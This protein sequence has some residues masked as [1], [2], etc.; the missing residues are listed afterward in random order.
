MANPS[1]KEAENRVK[2]LR[3]VINHHRTLYHVHDK[4]EISDEALDSLKN[5]L[6]TLEDL[7]PELIT[8]DSPTQRVGGSALDKFSKIEH[9]VAQWSFD[10]AFSEDDIRA[11]DERVKRQLKKALDK[12]VTPTYTV[13]LKID[14]FKVILSYKQGVLVTAAT[15]GDGK[16]GEDVTSNIKTIDSIP[17]RLEEEIDVVAEGEIW[18]GDHE[19]DRI[20]KE[21]AKEGLDLYA[22]PR[23]VAAGTVRQLDPKVVATRKLDSFI[24]DLAT[25]SASIPDTQ[26]S[27]LQRLQELGFKTNPHAKL[28]KNIEQVIEFWQ[29]WQNAKGKE[30]YWIDGVVVKVNERE[31]QEALG[32]TGK[33]PRF[34]IAFKFPAEQVT[35]VVE[36]IAIQV[37]RTGVMTPV[38]HLRPVL[39]AGSTVSRAT[40]HNEDEINRLDVRVGDTVILQ[41]AGDIIPDVVEVLKDL[42]PNSSKPYKFP[43]KCPA[44]GSAIERLPG[45][46]AHRCTSPNCFAQTLRGL[47]HFASKAAF[48]IEGVGPKVI[49]L[50]V[51]QNLIQIPADLFELEEGDLRDLPGLGEISAKNIVESIKAR[52]KVPLER[53][54]YAL[55]IPDV[56]EETAILL[57]STFGELSKIRAAQNSDLES[58]D[59]IGEVVA[60]KI[61]NFF[62]GKDKAAEIDKLLAHVSIARQKSGKTTLSGKTFVLTGTLSE[63]SRDEAKSMIRRAGGDVSSSVSSK[64]DYVLAGEN[65]GSKLDKAQ[66]MG[67]TIID[68]EQFG[69]L[70]AQ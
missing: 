28:A 48:N 16:V 13:E 59:G 37:G 30:D 25:S 53:F 66:E 27:E 55:G 19:L 49:D 12:D 44:C 34:A 38:A 24:Y 20:N 21:R 52:Q 39:V 36:D 4:S 9:S 70:I 33:A 56:G 50:L 29:K 40:L 6:K 57:A 65:A 31:Y 41:K 8:P 11:F 69:R 60:G 32:Y 64:T 17:L 22:N 47:H 1:K 5:E 45:E 42:R 68:E 61:T 14:G 67:V 63:L 46:A 43:K 26:Q 62:A 3:E 23:N 2:K 54:I 15:R 7:Y 35:T 10:D 51:E 18:M 58:I